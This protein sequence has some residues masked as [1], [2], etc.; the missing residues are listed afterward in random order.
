MRKELTNLAVWSRPASLGRPEHQCPIFRRAVDVPAHCELS[1]LWAGR[2]LVSLQLQRP[3]PQCSERLQSHPD[4]TGLVEVPV[5]GG[6]VLGHGASAPQAFPS[7]GSSSE[8]KVPLSPAPDGLGVPR[9]IDR[10]FTPMWNPPLTAAS[11]PRFHAGLAAAE[12]GLSW[13]KATLDKPPYALLAA[14]EAVLTRKRSRPALQSEMHGVDTDV[15]H[16]VQE[17]PAD[18]PPPSEATGNRSEHLIPPEATDNRSEHSTF[19]QATEDHM[20]RS[21]PPDAIE[22]PSRRASTTSP[23]PSP[24][25]RESYRE[26]A[27][28][29]CSTSLEATEDHLEHSTPGIQRECQN[30]EE[31]DCDTRRKP[32]R[33]VET[34]GGPLSAHQEPLPDH[35][36][37]LPD[38]QEPLPICDDLR[39]ENDNLDSIRDGLDSSYSKFD[40]TCK[41]LH[42]LCKKLLSEKEELAETLA[43]ERASFERQIGEISRIVSSCKRVWTMARVRKPTTGPGEQADSDIKVFNAQRIMLRGKVGD[44]VTSPPKTF[45]LDYIFPSSSFNTDV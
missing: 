10:S 40:S 1:G 41:G 32:E 2:D 25:A 43:S 12:R 8:L 31:L 26:H 27:P 23:T 24:E 38:H 44:G 28:A 45:R 9:I 4:S 37:P 15:G 17:A 30:S 7:V 6:V 16:D 36:E 35:Q 14:V 22:D 34:P 21:T 39:F 11:S 20:E 13:S 33:A 42:S 19:S 29:D 18:C 5:G 3:A